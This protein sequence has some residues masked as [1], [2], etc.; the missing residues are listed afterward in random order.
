M[1]AQIRKI[2]HYAESTIIEGYKP[3]DSPWQQYAVAAVIQNPWAG[4]YV[5]DLSP[6]ISSWAPELGELLT[7]EIVKMAGGAENIEAYGKAAVVGGSGE[8]EHGSGMIHTLKFGNFYRQALEAK[9]YLSFTNTRGGEN[10]AIMIPMMHIHD[11]GKRSHYLTI[12]FSIPDAPRHDE[13]VVAL[14]GAGSGRPH[15]RI[16]DRYQDLAEM[17]ND[18]D[19]PAAVTK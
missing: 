7:N 19:N 3:A 10:A 4:S 17:G 5:E 1:N 15:H 11:L 18:L 6:E 12:Q 9:S 13:M 14:G 16:G 8:I 2:V